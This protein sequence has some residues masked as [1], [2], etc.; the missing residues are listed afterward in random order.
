V[1]TLCEGVRGI[2][3]LALILSAC[4][5]EHSEKPSDKSGV[6]PPSARP[7]VVS[8]PAPGPSALREALGIPADVNMETHGPAVT[9]AAAKKL[10]SHGALGDLLEGDVYFFTAESVQP[11]GEPPA[12]TGGGEQT[13]VVVGAKVKIKAKSKLT[14]SPRELSL[15]SGGVTLNASMD[16]KRELEGCTPLLKISWLK[17]DDV[18]E[19]F[20]LFDVPTP[21][22]KN[23]RLS[24]LP[25][26][27]GGASA[28]GVKLPE[29]VT[30]TGARPARSAR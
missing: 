22:P 12:S 18:I 15:Q 4:R 8:R 23:L 9:P 1:R 28:T 11:C 24:Y 20:V 5:R 2:I 27:W 16:L 6:E 19:G 29:C 21:E 10:K 26:R 3:A 30:C 13:T 25:T 14:F 17:K 7:E